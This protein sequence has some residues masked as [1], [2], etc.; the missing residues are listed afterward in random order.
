M[1]T[2]EQL[3][4]VVLGTTLMVIVSIYSNNKNNPKF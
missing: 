4:L 2:V 1:E 3:A